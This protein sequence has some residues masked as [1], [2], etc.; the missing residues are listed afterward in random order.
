MSDETNEPQPESLDASD[1]AQVAEET[2]SAVAEVIPEIKAEVASKARP[3]NFRQSVI[4][5]DQDN[6]ILRARQN[7]FIAYFS[8]K[9][10]AFFRMEFTAEIQ[11]FTTVKYSQFVSSIP[12][13]THITLFSCHP[14]PGVGILEMSPRIAI[15]IADRLLGGKGIPSSTERALTEIEIGLV[16]DVV[17]IILEEWCQIWKTEIE[18][19]PSID[20]HEKSAE[21]LQ[22]ASLD[23][24][25]YLLTLDIKF[26]GAIEPMQIGVPFAML[27]A[28]IKKIQSSHAKASSKLASAKANARVTDAHSLIEVPVTAQWPSIDLSIR[29][30]AGFR[31]GDI[32]EM[33]ASV[34]QETCLLLNGSP[35]FT[36]VVGFEGD[37]VAIQIVNKITT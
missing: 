9:L 19:R 6:R 16:D 13:A 1:I 21:Y 8:A 17:I 35:K 24:S 5:T 10:S 37:A 36:G 14:L 26:A 4:L 32:I 15:S 23:S 20:S 27:E 11:Q 22:T 7:D 3:F 31:V 25:V 12:S 28:I 29:E 18:S 34:L 33:P 2:H 30:V